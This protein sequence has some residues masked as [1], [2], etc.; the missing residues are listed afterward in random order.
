MKTMTELELRQLG[1]TPRKTR[2][3]MVDGTKQVHIFTDNEILQLVKT[4]TVE[5]E[6]NAEWI[7][8]VKQKENANG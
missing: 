5:L 6:E 3:S 1:R 4:G 7:T 8:I 2:I